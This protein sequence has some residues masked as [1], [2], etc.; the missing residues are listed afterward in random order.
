M[1]IKKFTLTNADNTISVYKLPETFANDIYFPQPTKAIFIYLIEIKTEG[2]PS[3][4]IIELTVKG[5]RK[6]IP[7]SLYKTKLAYINGIYCW[8]TT[9]QSEFMLDVEDFKIM[10]DGLTSNF[11][12]DFYYSTDQKKPYTLFESRDYPHL[13]L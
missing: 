7:I 9:E 13:R 2:N 12:I 10:V 5:N 4:L 6:I 8:N 3:D 1:K 11:I